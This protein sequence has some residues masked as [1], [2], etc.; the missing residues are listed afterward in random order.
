MWRPGWQRNR[1]GL[2]RPL[3]DEPSRGY[4]S[5]SDPIQLS[6]PEPAGYTSIMV[7]RQMRENTKWIML[8]TALAFVGLMVFEWGMDLTGRSSA[9]LSGGEIGRVNGEPIPAQEYQEILNQ[10]HAQQSASG[11]PLSFAQGQQLEAAAWDQIVMQRLISQEL[12]RRGIEVTDAEVRQAARYAPPPEFQNQPVFQTDGQFD[13]EKYHAFLASPTTDPNLLLQLEA[14]YRGAIP[15]SKLY[16]QST[17]GM[18]VTD[19]ELWR[20]WR[21]ENERVR[22]RYIAFDPAALVPEGAVTVSDA[23]IRRY[24]DEHKDGFIRP[25]R[26][27]VKYIMLDRSPTASDT[28]AAKASAEGLRDAIAEG[29]F[30][31]VVQRTVEDSIVAAAGGSA[32]IR[33]GTTVPGLE[34]AAFS[35]ESGALSEPIQTPTGF[36]ILRVDS[37]SGD[38]TAYVHRLA[39]PIELSRAAEDS[40]FDRADSLDAVV[41]DYPIDAIGEQL[42]IPVRDAELIPGLAF[43][44]GLGMADEGADWALN[45]AVPGEVSPVF[46][47]PTAYYVFEL[48]NRQ[49]ERILTLEEATPTIRDALEAEKRLEQAKERV[50]GAVDQLDAGRPMAEVAAEYDTSVQETD[51]FSRGDIVPGIGRVNAVIGTAFG[52]TTSATSG[53]VEADG[54]LYIVQLLE[55]QEADRAEWEQQKDA[56]RQRVTQLLA[57]QRWREF[58]SELR[59]RAEIVDGRDELE[60]QFAQSNSGGL[61]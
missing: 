60:R 10:L 48:V 56:Q 23:E 26:A 31:E 12:R 38:S 5:M 47:T 51:L 52:L 19:N 45:Q 9:Q 53:V 33:R 57:E 4:H 17:A 15:Q 18:Y 58:L 61:F 7:M 25:A 13:I 39:V 24:Y 2:G 40:L 20:M 8:I 1:L 32:T 14:Y 22:I 35:Q 6:S 41:E 36:S 28:A 55:R 34:Q 44:P 50:R 54:K 11:Q 27:T 3:V 29:S 42:D 21:D 49:D 37:L 30:E 43:V 59:E 16:H 46:E